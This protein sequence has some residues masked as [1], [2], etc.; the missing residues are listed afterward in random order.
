MKKT[1]VKRKVTRRE[2]DPSREQ[3]DLMTEAEKIEQFKGTA[4]EELVRD[5]ECRVRKPTWDM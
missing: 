1:K 3:G 2:T 4:W 5:P